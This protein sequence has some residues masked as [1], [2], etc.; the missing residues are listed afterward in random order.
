M[1]TY[2]VVTS[3]V[4]SEFVPS[5]DVSRVYKY[6][7]VVHLCLKGFSETLFILYRSRLETGKDQTE[8]LNNPF[9]NF[10]LKG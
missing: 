6:V 3:F 2:I 10:V 5:T 8:M 1:H 9:F 4:V 7:R